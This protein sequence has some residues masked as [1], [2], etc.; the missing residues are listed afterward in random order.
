MLFIALFIFVLVIISY[1]I[2]KQREAFIRLVSAEEK[3]RS[4]AQSAVDAVIMCDRKGEIVFAN[5][6][7]ETIFGYTE[8]ELIGKTDAVLMPE[9]FKKAHF[10][11]IEK[12]TRNAP[13]ILLGKITELEAVKKDGTEFPIELSI[14]SWEGKGGM[15][16]TSV[17]RD[18]TERVELQKLRRDLTGMLVHDIKNPLAG[19]T[20]IAQACLDGLAGS[21]TPEQHKAMVSIQTSAKKVLHLV[22]NLLEIDKMEDR[23]FMP[24]KAAF[25][26][27]E[28]VKPLAWLVV[29]AESELKQ[30]SIVTEPE[31]TVFAEKELI[32]RVLENLLNNAVKH[33][34]QNGRIVL[35]IKKEPGRVLFEVIDNG[36]GIPKEYLPR[37][38]GKFFTVQEAQ[39]KTKV[40]TGLGLAFCKLAV[41]AHGGK[42]GVESEAGKG[43]RFW[44]TLPEGRLD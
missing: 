39:M 14:S 22:M 6:S 30:V 37:L 18:I 42:I 4:L 44:F 1:Y 31:I 15:F 40:D 3:F 43:S 2:F 20:A 25:K 13:P 11:G 36:E 21:F 17:I 27:E 9:R 24:Q 41:E 26:A 35:K 29:L 19:I 23:N 33:S 28:L 12:M 32:I 8:R 38:F 10:A 16:F 7:V 5:K 34:P